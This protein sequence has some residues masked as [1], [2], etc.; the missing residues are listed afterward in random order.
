MI[1]AAGGR[2]SGSVSKKTD[3]L[4]AGSSPGSKLN[5]AKDLGVK[6]VDQA[7]LQKMM[8]SLCNYS[9]SQAEAV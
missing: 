8:L 7:T 6:I 1:E 5:M 3:Y 9:R 4:V 2:V